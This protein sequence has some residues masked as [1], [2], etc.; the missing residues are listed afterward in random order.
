MGESV[1]TT[2]FNQVDGTLSC[3]GVRLE[4]IAREVGTPAYV[5]S[6]GAIRAQYAR[7]SEA[8]DPHPH[9]IHYSVK[10]N[11]NTAILALLRDL[12]AGVDIVSGGELFRVIRAGFTGND[13]VFSGVGK[14]D[15]ELCEA[16]AARVLLINVE[17]QGELERLAAIA[18]QMQVVAPVA[19]RVN[20]EVSVETPHPYTRTGERGHKFGIPFDDTLAVARLALGLPSI[21][22]V[23]L[24]MHIGSQISGVDAYENGIR[25]LL[26]LL[27]QTRAAGARDIRYIDIGGGLA[28][29]YD[30]EAPADAKAFADAVLAHVAPTG[31]ELI[32]EPG[33]FV[34]GNAGVLLTRVVDR[35]RNGGRDCIIADAGMTDLLRPSHYNAYHRIEAVRPRGIR[36]VFD[37]VG[38]VCESG[39]FFALGREMED[40][41]PGEL[42]AIHSS[43]AYGF[44]MASTYNSR[45]RIPEVLVDG[46]RVAVVSAR[47][48]YED[49]VRQEPLEPVWRVI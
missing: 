12:G 38:P 33:R 15:D 31:L 9:R 7:L 28:V 22:L 3:E 10:A 4:A 20:P 41:L 13:I 14:T 25:R 21:K 16:L 2:G 35:K 24:D 26:D 30:D 32:L 1:L 48:R 27:A 6:A 17:S 40:V 39:D 42:L 19:L 29:A 36:G 5:Y 46:D 37:I 18:K 44:V 11:S 23:G 43:G 47:E 49:L 8:L 34:V 45:P